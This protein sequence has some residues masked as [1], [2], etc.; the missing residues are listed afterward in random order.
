MMENMEKYPNKQSSC[1]SPIMVAVY[2]IC[3]AF[4]MITTAMIV[5]YIL[6]VFFGPAHSL[7]FSGV[8]TEIETLL[9]VAMVIFVSIKLR[10]QLLG[11]WFFAWW[12]V[13]AVLC[14]VAVY[15]LCALIGLPIGR[16]EKFPGVVV[17][18]PTIGLLLFISFGA[19]I[20]YTWNWIWTKLRGDFTSR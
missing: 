15:I 8:D 4:L 13:L 19:I 11:C 3:P 1:L 5:I 16:E 2:I 17:M 9:S 14:I 12:P 18:L 6:P 7:Y 20:Y 10:N